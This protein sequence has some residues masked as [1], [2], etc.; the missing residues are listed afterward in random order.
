MLYARRQILKLGLGAAPLTYFLANRTPLF[1]QSAA[2]SATPAAKAKPNSKFKGVQVGIIAPYAFQG[3]AGTAEDILKAMVE[4]GINAVELQAP[5]ADSFAGAPGGGARGGAAGLPGA[6]ADQQAAVTAI[7]DALAPQLQAAST[8]RI[9]LA[10]VTFSDAAA[11][12]ARLAD[13]SAAELEL[14]T[15]RAEA[16]SKLQSSAQRLT[17]EQID[18]LIVQSSPAP[19]GGARGARGGGGAAGA[20]DPV[21]AWRATVSMDRYKALRK[22][23]NDAG[24]SIYGYKMSL[25]LNA[26]ESDYKFA[27]DVVEALGANQLTMEL[28]GDAELT[29]RIGE[30]AAKRKLYASYHYHTAARFTSW[31]VAFGQSEYNAA[32]IDFG[33]YVGGSG[34]SPIPFIEKN[35]ARIASAHFKDKHTPANGG[36]NVPWGQGDTPIKEILQMMSKNGY[37][38]PATIELEYRVAGS[39]PMEE[40]A[41]C[42][43][44][45]KAALA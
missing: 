36:Q 35:H 37:T 13:L 45:A 44:Y 15:K 31:D 18:A 10:Q 29:K 7:N 4:L 9:N 1:A 23:Y 6:T 26:P 3:S 27:F 24:V 8:A 17:T 39:T 19:V 22:M 16:F 2:S 41:K 34:E 43:A 14:A 30:Y 42:L 12:K 40:I 33:H 25:G 28:P 32:N 11:I 38:F 20:A 21:T 5:P